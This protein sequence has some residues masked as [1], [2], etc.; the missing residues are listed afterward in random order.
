MSDPIQSAVQAF[1]F[2]NSVTRAGAVVC[3]VYFVFVMAAVWVGIALWRREQISWAVVVRVAVLAIVA[4]AL[5]RVFARVIVD[6][7]PYLVE[8]IRP[9]APTA[10]DNGFPSDHTL[11]AAFLTASLVWFA[12]RFIPVFCVGVLLVMAGRMGI[13][14]HHTLDVVGSVLIVAI[15]LL[16]VAVVPLPQRWSQPVLKSL[17]AAQRQR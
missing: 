10:T 16:A 17:Y 3:G 15:S 5:S 7:R 8:H 12:R 4:F 1:A 14:A 13:G 11:L 2:T 9:L 6:P